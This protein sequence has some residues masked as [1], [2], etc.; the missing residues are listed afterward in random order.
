MPDIRYVCL[1]D[2]HLGA[3]NSI[4]SRIQPGGIEVDPLT[5]SPVLYQL[6]ACLR[7]LIEQNESSQKP[8]L[9]LNGDILE[10]ALSDTNKAAMVFERFIDLVFPKDAEALFDKHMLY[11][12][13]NHDHHIWESA[14]ETQYV[15]FISGIEPG[16]ALA[17]PWHT[18]KMVM[19]D[20]VKEYFLTNLLQRFPHLHDAVVQVVYPNYA[21]FDDNEQKCIIFSH[22]H[23]I[24]PIYSLM[25]T[26]NT[27]MFPDRKKPVVIWDLEAENFAWVDFFWSTMGRSG[28]VGQDIGLFY[29]K[30]QDRQQFE[31]LLANFVTS[32]VE[33][34][35]QPEWLEGIEMAGLKLLVK[36]IL[37]RLSMFESKRSEQYLSPDGVQG[38][39]S[40][41]EGPLRE[42]L[43]IE[44]QQVIPQDITF[45]FGHTHKPFQ[46]L[47]GFEGYPAHVN[48]Y[49]SGG[50]V[51]DKLQ[52]HP[53]YG[54]ALILIDEALHPI[55]L[56]MYNQ[57]TNDEAYSVKVAESFRP[58]SAPS[59]FYT[60]IRAL[61]QPDRDPWKSFSRSVAEAVHIYERVLQTKINL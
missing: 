26:L 4:L 11:I 21:L 48:V 39:K 45:I 29:N 40:F 47:M 49:N 59:R 24:E 17:A 3:D 8:V 15:N 50:W 19:P 14:R 51:V 31:K 20:A 37:S 25:S 13:G 52:P 10:M 44:H 30:M 56:R 18:T 60:R 28:D 5:P 1:S 7:H 43:L 55:T 32:L 27:M 33:Q 53:V 41:M 57:A 36:L 9:V 58:G 23:Y 35:S 16:A 22:G 61:V 2:M 54:A 46:Q 38:L 42:Q 34:S 12:P 6:V